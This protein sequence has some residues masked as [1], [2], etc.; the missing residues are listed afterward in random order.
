M[1][2]HKLINSWKYHAPSMHTKKPGKPFPGFFCCDSAL[3]GFLIEKLLGSVAN[4]GICCKAND[5]RGNAAGLPFDRSRTAK[6]TNRITA[7]STPAPAKP[8]KRQ[9]DFTPL[10][11]LFTA[12]CLLFGRSSL[13]NEAAMPKWT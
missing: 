9:S 6:G 7:G 13:E 5:Y 11:P 10:P 8:R 1:G 12:C 4:K 3:H 2:Q